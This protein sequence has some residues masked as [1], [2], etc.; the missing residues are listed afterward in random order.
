MQWV[1]AYF[2]LSISPAIILRR[3]LHVFS[4]NAVLMGGGLCLCQCLCMKSSVRFTECTTHT[5][6]VWY[7]CVQRAMHNVWVLLLFHLI[8]I[9]FQRPFC[10]SLVAQDTTS[11]VIACLN[12]TGTQSILY[13]SNVHWMLSESHITVF[14]ST[15]K[16]F[17]PM[18][19]YRYRYPSNLLPCTT[20]SSNQILSHLA[21]VRTVIWI[22]S[23]EFRTIQL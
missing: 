10:V 8:A 3:T 14:G 12:C 23:T 4:S 16:T 19:G 6:L 5:P 1:V 18:Q 20:Q 17:I 7:V 9:T 2:T 13:F 15:L 21:N 11:Q 22:N